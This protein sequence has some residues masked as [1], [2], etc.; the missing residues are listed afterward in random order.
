[1]K[2]VQKNK[3][4]TLLEV[5]MALAILSIAGMSLLSVARENLV[6]SHYLSQKRPAWWVA[7]NAMTNIRLKREWPSE[8]W[9]TES[10]E[11]ANREWEVKS[12]SI[13]T[14]TDDFRMVE[15]EVRPL[16]S[17]ES[18][19]LAHLQTHILRPGS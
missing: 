8:Q 15:V 5:M 4:F 1:M 10:Q 7:E 19:P 14:Q 16:E 2:P 11:L 13:K 17:P 12:R 18:V 6:N 9:R 3:G